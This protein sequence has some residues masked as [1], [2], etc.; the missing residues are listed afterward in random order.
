MHPDLI[1]S[2]IRSRDGK[3]NSSLHLGAHLTLDRM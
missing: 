2:R 3:L 1:A